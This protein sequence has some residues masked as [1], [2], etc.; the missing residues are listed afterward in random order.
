MRMKEDHMCNGQLKPG[1]NVNVAT[2]SEYAVGTYVSADRTDTKTT[3]P[4]ME[5]LVRAYPVQRSSMIPA[6]R[7]R[8]PTTTSIIILR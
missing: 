4:F 7:V 1:Y 2:V 5:K 8:K 3:I 6:M